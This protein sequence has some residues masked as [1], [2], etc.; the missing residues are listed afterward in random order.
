MAAGILSTDFEEAGQSLSAWAVGTPDLPS[1]E[2]KCTDSTVQGLGA[3]TD[4]AFMEIFFPPKAKAAGWNLLFHIK[5]AFLGRLET[6]EWMDEETRA[7]AL[8]KAEKLQVQPEQALCDWSF[9]VVHEPDLWQSLNL[10][11]CS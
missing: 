2:K 6:I 4:I 7:K 5:K 3:L 8:D 1:R 11:S 10:S 9:A